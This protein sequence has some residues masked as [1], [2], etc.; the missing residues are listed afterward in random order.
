MQGETIPGVKLVR[1]RANRRWHSEEQAVAVIKSFGKDPFEQKLIS[2]AAA[3]KLLGV[4]KGEIS[5]LIVKPEGSL[6][7][8]PESDKRTAVEISSAEDA[9]NVK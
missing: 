8:A 4:D 9:F 7:V 6:Q 2:P 1:G 3:E 5:P